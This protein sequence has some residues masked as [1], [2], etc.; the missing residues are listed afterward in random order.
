MPLFD[1][2][3]LA[4][5]IGIE[6]DVIVSGEL[7]AVTS[8]MWARTEKVRVYLQQMVDELNVLFYQYVQ[9]R[10]PNMSLENIAKM[11]DGRAVVGTKAV[12]MGI[13]DELGGMLEAKKW[14]VSQG[15]L[16]KDIPVIE[17]PLKEDIP[18][19]QKAMRGALPEWAAALGQLGKVG[20]AITQPAVWAIMK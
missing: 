6:S 16:A 13:V 10:R 18:W 1:V 15:N 4:H 14:V 3:E 7:K 2:T 8:P 20:Q 19:L 12:K 11:K 9:E 5:K 17:Y